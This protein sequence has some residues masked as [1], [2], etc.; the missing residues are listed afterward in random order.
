MRRFFTLCVIFLAA[1]FFIPA[2]HAEADDNLTEN[3]GRHAALLPF[4]DM[5]IV[6]AD[7]P[8]AVQKTH[9]AI[10]KGAQARKWQ[11]TQ[12]TPTTVRLRLN[13]R[14]KHFVTVDAKIKGGNVDIVYVDSENMNYGKL[15]D[16]QEIIHP[17]YNS[18][19]KYLLKSAR[20]AA[21]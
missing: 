18:W 12:D 3:T 5:V 17:K 9:D 2:A 21:K 4:N 20:N 10:V 13:V 15:S 16:G 8:D 11:V 19:V 1:T 7:L 14:N 6:A